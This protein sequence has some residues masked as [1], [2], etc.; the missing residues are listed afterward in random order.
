MKI[1]NSLQWH[2]PMTFEGKKL[3]GYV[4]SFLPT[5]CRLPVTPQ[6]PAYQ[7][8]TVE[9]NR[10]KSCKRLKIEEES[11]VSLGYSGEQGRL[12]ALQWC[13]LLE[14]SEKW[15]VGTFEAME[16]AAQN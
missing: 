9:C 1:L 16:D 8:L 7:E 3:P 6:A 12:E 11:T 5:I 2:Q 15:I 14:M 4:Y 10:H 13:S